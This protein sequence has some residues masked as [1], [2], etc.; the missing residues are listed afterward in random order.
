MSEDYPLSIN[1]RYTGLPEHILHNLASL[2][3]DS[4]YP[5]PIP[6]VR[7]SIHILLSAISAEHRLG[8]ESPYFLIL[9]FSR[10][11]VNLPA[12]KAGGSD[13]AVVSP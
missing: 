8:A 13:A 3:H 5:V 6:S 9:P 7:T 1:R 4:Y 11:T 2:S 10:D 12:T